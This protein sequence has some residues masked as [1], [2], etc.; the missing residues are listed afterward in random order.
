M[1]TDTQTPNQI[2][3]YWRPGCGFCSSLRGQ[4][5]KLGIERVEHNIWDEPQKASVVREHANGNETVPTVVI[6][7][8]G[9]VNPS[10]GELAAHLAEHAP[11]LLPDGFEA[12]Q[13][14]AVGRAIGKIFR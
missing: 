1:S 12:P 14:G 7:G 10:P 11:H 3:L 9:M 13:P 8:V 6:G 5:D 4:L 2:D